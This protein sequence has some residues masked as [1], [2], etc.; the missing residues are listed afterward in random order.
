MASAY[1][2]QLNRGEWVYS[3][4]RLHLEHAAQTLFAELV[5]DR[6]LLKA[7]EPKGCFVFLVVEAAVAVYY[8]NLWLFIKRTL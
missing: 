5:D 8:Q 1:Y 4:W 7:L 6:G 3:H 2:N